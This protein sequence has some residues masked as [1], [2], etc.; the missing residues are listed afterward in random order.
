[1]PITQTTLTTHPTTPQQLTT[2]LHNLTN[3]NDNGL[4]RTTWSELRLAEG[5]AEQGSWAVLGEDVAGLLPEPTTTDGY[6]DLDALLSALAD[7]APAPEL[8]L[9]R[10]PDPDRDAPLPAA[11]RTAAYPTLELLQRWLAAPELDQVRLVLVGTGA[12]A[13]TPGEHLAAPALAAVWGLV[14]SAQAENPDRI[15][16]LDLDAHPGTP[17]TA[18]TLAATLAAA[19]AAGEPQLAVRNNKPYTPRLTPNT[20]PALTPPQDAPN[21]RLEILEKGTLDSLTLAPSG[22]GEEE[23]LPSGHVRVAIHAAGLNFRDSLIA[24]GLYPEDDAPFGSEAAGI[25]THAAEDV[26]DFRPGDRVYGLF[27]GS[28]T[29]FSTTDQRYLARTPAHFTHTEAATTAVVH[30]TAY[31]ALKHL[32]DL[33]PHHHL[34]IHAAT[35]GV[36]LAALNIARHIGA[37]VHTTTSVYKQHHL[38]GLGVPASHI[39]NSRDLSFEE[40]VNATTDG[41]GIDF[42]LHSLTKEYTDATLRLLEP[43]KGHLIDIGKLDIRDADTVGRDHPGVGYS[44]F[45][46]FETGPDHIQQLLKELTALFEARVLEPLPITAWEISDAP[47][48]LRHLASGRHIGKLALTVPQPLDPNGTVLITGATGTLGAHVARHLATH[49]HANRFL[50]LSRSGTN[51]PGAD[52]LLTELRELGAHADLLATDTA[53]HH[54]LTEAL[55]TIPTDHPLTGVFHVAGV[56]DDGT[57]AALTPERLDTVLRPKADAAWHLH[58][59]T[60]HLDLAAF[61]LFSS[62][63]GTLGTPGQANYAAANAALDALAHHRH[64][65]G[66]PATSIA[67]GLWAETSTLTTNLQSTDRSRLNR[68]GAVPLTTER[69]L[70]LLDAALLSRQSVLTAVQLDESALRG[71]A[72]A[73]P[74]LLRGLLRAPA[75]RVAAA[76]AAAPSGPSLTDRLAPLNPSARRNLLLDL[77]RGEAAVVLAH[78]D[79][80][81]LAPDQPF[82]DLGFDSLTAVELRNRLRAATG[83]HLP[84]TLVFDHPTPE[85]LAARLLADLAVPEQG[86][87]QADEGAGD[88]GA[89][90]LRALEASMEEALAAGAAVPGALLGR[91]RVLLSRLEAG[92]VEEAGADSEAIDLENATHDEIFALIDGGSS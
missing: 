31:H 51:A 92:G 84:T 65:H 26:S 62:A 50:L 90:G 6:A 40:H 56:L 28:I 77:V 13:V 45:D 22:G 7:G 8:V 15:T 38:A 64:T 21:W 53:D 12:A 91:L 48:A 82:K 49:H 4:L 46:L 86:S 3:T 58:R 67:W 41:Q 87:A 27:P 73:A 23:S 16:L 52:Q 14:R 9:A 42:A 69:G 85:A 30:L 72:A 37:T 34:L 89:A 32:A 17:A 71:D 35:G 60:E 29:R 33:Q 57:L 59:L 83:L 11:V 19:H 74:A 63:A 43:R 5:A 61:V 47:A 18:E 55:A 76:A 10:I 79:A 75:R 80:A 36:G 39:S 20:A 25:V 88:E 24:L 78:P 44:Y 81:R 54:A 68:S 2:T 66:L 1:T 70:A